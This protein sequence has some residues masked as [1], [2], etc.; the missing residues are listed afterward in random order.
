MSRGEYWISAMILTV[1]PAVLFIPR[2][3]PSE[4]LQSLA[5]RIS[6]IDSATW[7]I[8]AAVSG[9][10]ASALLYLTAAIALRQILDAWI[11][12]RQR[13][14]CQKGGAMEA[15]NEENANGFNTGQGYNQHKPV[16][17]TGPLDPDDLKML[18]SWEGEGGK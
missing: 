14:S 2:R 9:L 18:E 11:N 7:T 8:I 17:D 6:T 13:K 16:K 10:T 4:S 1:V 15:R 5:N 12:D 3:D